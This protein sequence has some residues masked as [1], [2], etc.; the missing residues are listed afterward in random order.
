M[1]R[2]KY[3]TT[4]IKTYESA[5]HPL[6]NTRSSSYFLVVPISALVFCWFFFLLEKYIFVTGGYKIASVTFRFFFQFEMQMQMISGRKSI[7]PKTQFASTL[8][9]VFVWFDFWSFFSHVV[10]PFSCDKTRVYERRK[11]RVHRIIL[12]T[13]HL[14]WKIN[15]WKSNEKD[16]AE[17]PVLMF[18]E[19]GNK[20]F[21]LHKCKWTIFE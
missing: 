18:S 15:F 7:I 9:S 6:V 11:K 12:N 1:I 13:L 3:Y 14:I 5:I 21:S 17:D 16:A 8:D 4:G 2:K 20:D 19:N 10:G